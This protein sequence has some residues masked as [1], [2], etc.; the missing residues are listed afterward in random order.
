MA[1]NLHVYPK[2]GI[3]G[4]EWWF[5]VKIFD[6]D[7]RVQ[8]RFEHVE[9]AGV[10]AEVPLT[11]LKLCFD[12]VVED[13]DLDSDVDDALYVDDIKPGGGVK[14]V[15]GDWRD[16]AEAIISSL[17]PGYTRADFWAEWSKQKT[18]AVKADAR[19]ALI[20]QRG[21]SIPVG[22]IH[23]HEGDGTVTDE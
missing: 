23:Q 3:A 15:W 2:A 10:T 7:T 14:T 11:L 21:W 8:S 6:Q 13:T 16:V 20:T 1:R 12:M 22:S 9:T 4:T 5:L 18:D 19:R 17:P